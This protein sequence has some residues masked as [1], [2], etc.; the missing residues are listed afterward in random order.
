[1]QFSE[2]RESVLRAAKQVERASELLEKHNSFGVKSKPKPNPTSKSEPSKGVTKNVLKLDTTDKSIESNFEKIFETTF[3]E[4][5]EK[6]Q[7]YRDITIG[8]YKIKIRKSIVQRR[9]FGDETLDFDI[10]SIQST[11]PK[12]GQAVALFKSAMT[13]ANKH[14]RG[15]FLEQCVTDDSRGWAQ[16]LVKLGLVREYYIQK[17]YLSIFPPPF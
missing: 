14:G 5:I 17:S 13:A 6:E 7:K 15:I 12:Q 11:P 1:M 10:A 3:S 16:K 2:N 4:M 8:T 9:G